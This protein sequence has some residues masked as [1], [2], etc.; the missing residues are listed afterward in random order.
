MVIKV[1]W[2]EPWFG[3]QTD[4]D[5]SLVDE[6]NTRLARSEHGLGLAPFEALRYDNSVGAEHADQ[7]TQDIAGP[8]M[9]DHAS[10]ADTINRGGV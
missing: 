3:V 4:F 8:P 5:I 7:E 9:S 2:S 10:A 1:Q 6:Q